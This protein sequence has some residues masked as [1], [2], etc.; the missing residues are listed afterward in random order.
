MDPSLIFETHQALALRGVMGAAHPYKAVL[1]NRWSK[2][3]TTLGADPPF[4]PKPSIVTQAGGPPAGPPGT[5]DQ[6]LVEFPKPK[7]NPGGISGPTAVPPENA[8][9]YHLILDEIQVK[10][11]PGR[12]TIFGGIEQDVQRAIRIPYQYYKVT[13]NGNALL[14]KEYVTVLYEG[15]AGH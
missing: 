6:D 8:H 13:G 4:F 14:V 10:D 1:P 12:Y 11:Y 3:T 5:T 15:G 2:P 9:I 7:P